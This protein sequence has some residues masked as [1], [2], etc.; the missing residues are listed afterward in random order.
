MRLEPWGG[1]VAFNGALARWLFDHR[2][3]LIDTKGKRLAMIL[4]PK[5]GH[6]KPH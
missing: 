1:R 2:G 5:I 4:V 6:P 3:R